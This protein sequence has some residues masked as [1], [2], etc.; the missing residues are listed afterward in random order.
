M[1]KK[2]NRPAQGKKVRF[3]C[4]NKRKPRHKTMHATTTNPINIM[5]ANVRGIKG[6]AQSLEHCLSMHDTHIATLTETKL[7]TIPPRVKGYTWI[8]KNKKEGAG[9][10]AVLV[11]EKLKNK[12]KSIQYLDDDDTE[13][14]WVEVESQGK[15][16]FIGVIYGKQ[17]NAP[18][19]EVERQFQTITTHILTLKQKGKVI[20]TG[21]MNAKIKINKTNYD[22]KQIIQETSRNGKLLEKMLKDTKTKAISTES[23]TGLWTRINTKNQNEKSIIDYIIIPDEDSKNV[24]NIE[25]DEQE[26]YKISG[27]KKSDHN[28]ITMTINIPVYKRTTNN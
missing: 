17:E 2:D 8:T 5:Y 28:T 26:I 11:S 4:T 9:G 3:K 6:K 18:I 22:G 15:P 7:G 25:V 16:T 23:K 19:E 27:E 24:E 13:I 20:L 14:L 10:I 1:K 21:D 12:T